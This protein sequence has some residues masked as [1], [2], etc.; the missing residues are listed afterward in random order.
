MSTSELTAAP[1]VAV[2]VRRVSS[3]LLRSELGLVFRRRRNIA[4]LAVLA[5]GPILLGLAVRLAAPA[6]GDGPPFLSQVTQ[7][8]LFLGLALVVV[9][10][11]L[12]LPLAISVV[13]GESMA[14]EASTGTLRNLLVVPASRAR[15]LAVKYGG[16][17]AFAL[18][19]AVTVVGVGIVAGLAMFPADE[20]TLLSGTT[21][22]LPEAL[23]RAA[24]VTL[25]VAAML[26][27]VGAIGVFVSTLTEVPMGA[28]AATATITVLS[29]ILDTIPQ[30]SVIHEYLYTHWWLAF[31]D[32]LRD[33]MALAEIRTGLLTQAVYIV[34]FGTLA[35]ARFTTKDITA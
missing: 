15:L 28:M 25:Y 6:P 21:V 8:G 30:V 26:A 29:Q 18:A 9:A 22:G 32:L 16:V 11:P 27:T 33:P 19:C 35:W 23:Y 12:F 13:S 5:S 1:I 14:G 24:L 3:R 7:N 31:A 10:M 2:P 17:A 34:V 4:M 20:L